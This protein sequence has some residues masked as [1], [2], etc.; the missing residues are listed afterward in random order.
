MRTVFLLCGYGKKYSI[1]SPGT[2]ASAPP[3]RWQR[4]QPLWKGAKTKHDWFVFGAV[5][6]ITA[7]GF[8][9]GVFDVLRYT[10]VYITHPWGG[11]PRTIARHSRGCRYRTIC[12]RKALG[13]IFLKLTFWGPILFQLWRYTLSCTVS[14]AYSNHL[15]LSGQVPHL[16]V[17]VLPSAGSAVIVLFKWGG[18]G[19]YAT[20]PYLTFKKKNDAF[21]GAHGGLVNEGYSGRR[22]PPGMC[23]ALS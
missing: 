8:F 12:P 11:F 16:I 4:S 6:S 17:L 18:G 22:Y 14:K 5:V 20:I 19:W 10:T 13:E 2:A 15:G 7:Q 23:G 9:N 21:C 3:R 1:H